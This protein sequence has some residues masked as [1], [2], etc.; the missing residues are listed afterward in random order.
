MRTPISRR[1][2][3]RGASVSLGLP[4]LEAMASPVPQKNPV[5]MAA[6]YMTNGVNV[7]AWYPEDKGRDFTLSPTLAPLQDLKAV[8]SR[9]TIL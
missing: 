8:L 9:S 6:L 4:W 3:L 2:L 1:T 5:R 7:N